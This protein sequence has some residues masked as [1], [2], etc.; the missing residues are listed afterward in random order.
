MVTQTKTRRDEREDEKESGNLFL[1][2]GE[3]KNCY[4]VYC[5]AE[6]DKGDITLS[7]K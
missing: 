3:Y 6:E 5:D 1:W 7:D 4:N 2:R